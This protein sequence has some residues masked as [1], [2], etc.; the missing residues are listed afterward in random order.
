MRRCAV[1]AAALAVLAGCGGSESSR[2][3][4]EFVRGL[5]QIRSSPGAQELHDQLARTLASLRRESAS[6]ATARQ[7][8]QLA[9]QGFASTLRGVDAQIDLIENDSGKL[10]AAARDA[11]KADRYRKRGATLLRSAGRAFGISVGRLGGY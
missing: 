10:E 6:T 9:I 4:D 8:R 11:A 3:E 2:L 7:G 1:A 5:E